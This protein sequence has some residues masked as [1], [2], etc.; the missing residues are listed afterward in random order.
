MFIPGVIQRWKLPFE[1]R[2]HDHTHPEYRDR[3]NPVLADLVLILHAA[4]I[5]FVVCG[6]LLALW[7]RPVMWLHVPAVV[8]TILLEFYGWICPLTPLENSLREAGGVPG[9]RGGFMEHYLLPLVYPGGLTP[10]IRMVLGLAALLINL[11]V[12]GF[13]W[14]WWRKNRG[15]WRQWRNKRGNGEQE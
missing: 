5:V 1:W 12:Y 8:W 9:Y 10:G 7:W 6:G 2:K 4:F 11:V 3:S 13:V 15:I 14:W